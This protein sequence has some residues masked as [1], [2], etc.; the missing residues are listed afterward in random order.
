MNFKVKC[1][2]NRG[3]NG[4][5]SG[6]IYEVINGKITDDYRGKR[7]CSISTIDSFYE[8]CEFYELCD[9]VLISDDIKQNN[10]K[11]FTLNDLKPFMLVERRNGELLLVSENKIGICLFGKDLSCYC[12]MS[13]D[14]DLYLKNKYDYNKDIIKVYDLSMTTSHLF[15]IKHREL[16]FN[17]N[18][19]VHI[20]L[21]EV[22]DKFNLEEE[23][24]VIIDYEGEKEYD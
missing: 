22:K 13:E 21:K 6:K 24:I 4:F 17:V 5:T 18:K 16:I 15:N 1:T 3:E 7:P 10:L 23:D 2:K 12:I 11:N 20:S 14:Y 9:F 8:L 19:E